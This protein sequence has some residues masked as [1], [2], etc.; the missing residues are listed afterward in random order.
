MYEEH[1]R[2]D[3]FTMIKVP[4]PRMMDEEEFE[5]CLHLLEQD[6]SSSVL[7]S[8]TVSLEKRTLSAGKKLYGP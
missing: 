7:Y 8:L 1:R 5:G 3:Y 4:V 6:L 2:P